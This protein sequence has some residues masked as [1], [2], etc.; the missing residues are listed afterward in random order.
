VSIPFDLVL[1]KEL[2]VTSGFAATSESWRRAMSLLS[3]GLID[4]APMISSVWSLR[5]WDEVIDSLRTGQGMKILFDPRLDDAA[6]E[7]GANAQ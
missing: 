6:G 4:L 2:T 3:R 5:H 7:S 1:Y